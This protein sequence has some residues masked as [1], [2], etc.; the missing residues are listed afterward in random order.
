MESTLGPEMRKTTCNFRGLAGFFQKSALRH[1]LHKTFSQPAC[2]S[3]IPTPWRHHIIDAFRRNTCR[4]WDA[5]PKATTWQA[6]WPYIQHSRQQLP[7]AFDAWLAS[8]TISMQHPAMLGMRQP[9]LNP[10]HQLV[11]TQFGCWD[12]NKIAYFERLARL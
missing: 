4:C 12:A 10:I 9:P 2:F 3:L 1:S 6:G 5:I 7:G 11:H 8:L